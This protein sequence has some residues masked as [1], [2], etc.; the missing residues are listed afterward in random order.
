MRVR[1]PKWAPRDSVQLKIAGQS[2][3]LRWDGSYLAIDQ[4]NV[5][6]GTTITLQ[7]DLPEKQTVEEMPVSH[8]QFHLTWRGDEVIA[9]DPKVPIYPG[10][11]A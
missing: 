1:V 9:C 7:H 3:P 6:P 4:E 11:Q 2:L 10:K 5:S 8:R